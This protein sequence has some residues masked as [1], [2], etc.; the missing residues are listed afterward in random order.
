MRLPALLLALL[1][2]VSALAGPDRIS[3]L[4]GSEHF[5]A[6]KE[7]QEFNPGVFLTWEG[8]YDVSAGIYYNSY[9]EVGGLV[10][11]GRDF[12]EGEDYAVGLFG[13]LALYPGD[14]D[15]FDVSI[16]DVVPLIGLQ[17]RYRNVF[18]QLIPGNGETT[19]AVLA[20]GLTWELP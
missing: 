16:G 2:P 8:R 1:L 5:N 17:A 14:G 4:L 7:F 11:L 10:A 18:A 15:R 13:A 9:E 3:V 20:V 19:D 12:W 6:T